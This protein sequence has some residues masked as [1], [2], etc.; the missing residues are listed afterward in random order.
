MKIQAMVTED[1]IYHAKWASWHSPDDDRRDAI[2]T[3]IRDAGIEDVKIEIHLN[4]LPPNHDWGIW[5][6]GKRYAM[7][8]ALVRYYDDFR[9]HNGDRTDN[10]LI[11]LDT[12]TMTASV[13]VLPPD[14]R[15]EWE[16][17]GMTYNEYRE[18][19]SLRGKKP[20]PITPLWKQQ[21]GFPDWL[22]AKRIKPLS[23]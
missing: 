12:D 14:N 17:K 10:A 18:K 7:S 1:H 2:E 22:K 3:A 11:T 16:K 4:L 15:P 5:L 6:N 13:Q 23:E 9:I 20:E 21:D 8:I 19:V